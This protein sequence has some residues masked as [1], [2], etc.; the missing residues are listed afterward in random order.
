[1]LTKHIRILIIFAVLT[2][3]VFSTSAALA[4]F[5]N[6]PENPGPIVMRGEDGLGIWYPDYKAG[7]SVVHGID[8]DEFCLGIEDYDLIAYQDIESPSEV[9]RIISVM[10]G[11]NITT[12]VW[13]EVADFDCEIY[14]EIEPIATGTVR[15]LLT[16]NDLFGGGFGDGKPNMNAFTVSAH[17]KLTWTDG[18]GLAHYNGL[19]NCVWDGF[20]FPDGRFKCKDKINIH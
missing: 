10:Q 13:P 3:L 15:I 8:V 11:D 17:G 7:L 4:N 1:M 14:S 20:D 6:G 19:S 16:D 9:G 18:G 2:G 5:S 12:S